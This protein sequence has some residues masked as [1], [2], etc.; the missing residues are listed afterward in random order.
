MHNQL[1]KDYNFCEKVIKKH[2]KSFYFAFNKLPKEKARAVFAIYTFCRYAD[3]SV[4]NFNNS[5]EKQSKIDK[6]R[7]ELDYFSKGEIVDSPL[8]RA[9]A[10]VFE[11]YDMD[12]YPFW[13][14]LEGQQM[15]INF[16]QP[17]TLQELENYCSYV[18]GSVGRMLIPIIASQSIHGLKKEANDL[19]IAMQLTNI[20]RDVG[21]DFKKNNRIYLPLQEM[22]LVCYTHVDI[23]DGKRNKEFIMIWEKLANRAETLYE[24]FL[25]Q[26][27]YF[28]KDSQVPIRLSAQVYRGILDAI[29]GNDYNCFEY[30]NYVP[31]PTMKQWLNQATSI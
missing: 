14:Q 4:D 23:S 28:D 21:E 26:L 7:K 13:E 22:S 6:I 5:E 24:N 1:I 27:D 29:R 15:D 8:W 16:Q 31:L 18:A 11:R 2:S 25:N 30:R 19:G 9:L 12:L 10:D 20:L 3:D 17:H